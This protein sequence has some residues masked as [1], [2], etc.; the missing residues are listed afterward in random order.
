[1]TCLQCSAE[2]EMSCRARHRQAAAPLL[3]P[4]PS[5]SPRSQMRRP[6]MIKP[7]SGGYT[8]T[9]AVTWL[10]RYSVWVDARFERH[11]LQPDITLHS[12]SLNKACGVWWYA[13]S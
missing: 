4:L 6:R 13:V 10:A 9:L 12:P 11:V 5:L 2:Q 1:M 7:R 3:V 8:R